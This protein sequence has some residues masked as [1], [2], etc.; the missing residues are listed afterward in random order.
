MDGWMGVSLMEDSRGK[1]ECAVR[2]NMGINGISL[3][4]D[5][6]FSVGP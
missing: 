6:F 1:E 2:G 5:H 3:L 4:H